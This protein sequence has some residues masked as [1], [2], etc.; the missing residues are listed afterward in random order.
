M[1]RESIGSEHLA[2]SNTPSVHYPTQPM[3]QIL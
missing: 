3:L 2:G 1:E